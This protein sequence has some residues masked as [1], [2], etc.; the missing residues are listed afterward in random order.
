MLRHASRARGL[1]K[2]L[3]F[4]NEFAEGPVCG[5]SD[6]NPVVPQPAHNAAR[7]AA[8]ST[9]DDEPTRRSLGSSECNE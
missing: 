3:Q 1:M 5:V 8:R 2:K 9:S 6:H 4:V 7:A